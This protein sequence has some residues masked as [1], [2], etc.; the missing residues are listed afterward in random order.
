MGEVGRQVCRDAG[1]SW[2]DL[3]GNAQIV[4]P[5]L[6]IHVEGKPN[7]YKRPGRPST[8]FSPRSSRIVRQLLIEPG[9]SLHQPELARLVGLDEG[10]TS[11]I[12]RKLEADELVG[13]DATG[14]LH[15]TNP[16]LAILDHHRYQAL[17]ERLRRTTV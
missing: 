9:R 11:R 17:T 8:V 6:R 16:G 15:V 2:L 12:V 14:A 3:S 4:A 7:A 13:R 1:V 5:G 10:F